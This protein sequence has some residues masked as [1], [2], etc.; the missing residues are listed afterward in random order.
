MARINDR[1]DQFQEVTACLVRWNAASFR[2]LFFWVHTFHCLVQIILKRERKMAE[3]RGKHDSL[4]FSKESRFRTVSS[5][6]SLWNDHIIHWQLQ[7]LQPISQIHLRQFSFLLFS[8]FPLFCI[9][10]LC[11]EHHQSNNS[12]SLGLEIWVISWC[13]QFV[14]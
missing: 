1:F 9:N 5:Y 2:T 10:K 12:S 4:L 8:S 11:E 13:F 7:K 6:Y 14:L 3:W